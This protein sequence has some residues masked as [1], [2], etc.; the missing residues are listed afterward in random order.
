[1]RAPFCIYRKSVILIEGNKKKEK[2]SMEPIKKRSIALYII[3]SIITC[4][5]FGIYWEYCLVND[6]NTATGNTDGK[7]GIVV[8][9]LNL[10]TC[11]IF[12]WIWVYKAG[13]GLD[14]VKVKNGGQAGNRAI[15]YLILSIFG[16]GIVAVALIQNELNELAVEGTS[17]T[18]KN[19]NTIDIE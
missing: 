9:L 1:M 7:N 18:E 15:L 10:I 6:T 17:T 16:L 11:G 13:E 2:M 4:G 14:T 12:W 3:L 19:E 8:I 5:L